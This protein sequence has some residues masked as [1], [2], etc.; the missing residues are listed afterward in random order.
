MWSCKRHVAPTA[1]EATE[2]VVTEAEKKA[3]AE[4]QRQAAEWDHEEEDDAE[5]MAALEA[6]DAAL[7]ALDSGGSGRNRVLTGTTTSL[8][9]CLK[10][11]LMRE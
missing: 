11:L 3:E 6:A 8:M 5:K 2:V 1:A 9:S 4:R 10:E 7:N